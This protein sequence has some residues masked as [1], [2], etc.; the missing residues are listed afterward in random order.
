MD[1]LCFQIFSLKS[2]KVAQN[3][4]KLRLTFFR[5]DWVI[6]ALKFWLE[7]QLTSA[8]PTLIQISIVYLSIYLSI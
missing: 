1:P 7:T 5:T 4:P 3:A 2:N 8:T 6:W